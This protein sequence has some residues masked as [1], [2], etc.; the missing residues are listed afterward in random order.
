MKKY[1]LIKDF[2]RKG[3][4][5]KA[6]SIIEL[7]LENANKFADGGFIQIDGVNKKTTS[8][9]TS[10]KSIEKPV[11]DEIKNENEII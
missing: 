10:K 5:T 2:K 4:T 8:K 1:E 3:K 7:S 11:I 9:K 6:G